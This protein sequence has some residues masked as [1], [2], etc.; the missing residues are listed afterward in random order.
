VAELAAPEGWEDG[1]A[2]G[3]HPIADVKPSLNSAAVIDDTV[4][5]AAEN[6]AAP[7]GRPPIGGTSRRKVGQLDFPIVRLKHQAWINLPAA[8][9]PIAVQP[10]VEDQHEHD[11]RCH[12]NAI[13]NPI[14]QAPDDRVMHES[15]LLRCGTRADLNKAGLIA[16]GTIREGTQIILQLGR[17][18]LPGPSPGVGDSDKKLGTA[19][20]FLDEIGGCP[21]F[22]WRTRVHSASWTMS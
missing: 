13:E 5:Y 4:I 1:G 3:E 18:S 14:D 10:H 6:P 16:T 17:A 2:G 19:T 12:G 11:Q 15:F 8:D 22:S 21:G 7:S 20:V 9:L